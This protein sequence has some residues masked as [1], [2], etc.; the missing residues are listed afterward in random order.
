MSVHQH[1]DLESFR[2]RLFGIA[3]RMLGTVE[4]AEDLVQETFLRWQKSATDGIV[5]PEGWLVSVITRLAI[6]RLRVAIRDRARY[7][8]PYLPE[9]IADQRF[10]AQAAP[11]DSPD[12]KAE[13]ASELSMAFLVLL[14]RLAPEERAAFLLRDVFGAEYS[15][16][17]RVLDRSEAATRQVIHRARERVRV[18][19][20]RFSVPADAKGKLLSRFLAALEADDPE[21]M[22]AVVAPEMTL[23]SDGGGK[24][25]AAR[26]V[27]QGAERVLRMLLSLE[28]KYGRP[29]TYRIAQV[30][31]EPA[32]L[33]TVHGALFSV[34]FME[35]DGERIVALYRVM[36]PDK[37]RRVAAD[38][39]LTVFADAAPQ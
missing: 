20:T 5:E 38:L 26:R 17:A 21:A 33:Q 37:L 28:R 2:P 19:R 29:F 36:N 14:E 24:V 23:T 30:N 34:T 9:P 13:L 15:E 18:D 25:S 16:I 1:V 27:V 35:T 10:L 3:Y 7:A 22:L 4:D 32:I 12:H 31:A 6:D 8:G 39:G 11:S